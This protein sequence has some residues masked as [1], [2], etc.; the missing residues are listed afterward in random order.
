MRLKRT[1]RRRVARRAYRPRK[2]L[3]RT[4]RRHKSVHT[5]IRVSYTVYPTMTSAGSS[6]PAYGTALYHIQNIM[7]NLIASTPSVTNFIAAYD[8][9]ALKSARVTYYNCGITNFS[10]VTNSATYPEV[11]AAMFYD[12]YN[13]PSGLGTQP[14]L[15]LSKMTG[16]SSV[17]G[18]GRM[19]KTFHALPICK[20]LN[21]PY[22]QPTATSTSNYYVPTGSGIIPTLTIGWNTI[23]GVAF[24][25]TCTP[26]V[27]R[28][29]GT[30]LFK[31]LKT[32]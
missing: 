24:P 25:G 17:V 1:G 12:P 10:N 18:R 13:N 11:H 4:G 27:I 15:A 14:A 28:I 31:N 8:F 29:T 30:L 7:Q 32:A 20:K 6:L 26:G 16:A 9:V 19:A 23:D 3:R 5:S 22:W 2:F 21:M